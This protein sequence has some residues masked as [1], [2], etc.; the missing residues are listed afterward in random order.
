MS[1]KFF[2]PSPLSNCFC[3]DSGFHYFNLT[4]VFPIVSLPANLSSTLPWRQLLSH[5]WL[6]A[7][8]WTIACQAP[9]S[10]G[11]SRQEY[12]SGLPLSFSRWPS[13][14]RNWSHISCVSRTAGRFFTT[15]SPGKPA[16]SQKGNSLTLLRGVGMNTLA[17]YSWCP[18]SNSCLLFKLINYKFLRASQA[19]ATTIVLWMAWDI[20]VLWHMLFPLLN[21]PLTLWQT[22]CAL[23]NLNQGSSVWRL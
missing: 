19:L 1:I 15:E 17:R 5:V 18:N 22:P 8:P 3:F 9:L 13:R 16:T 2:F 23:K 6:F 7:T 12:W 10:I 14:P 11:F 20:S 4:E 21:F